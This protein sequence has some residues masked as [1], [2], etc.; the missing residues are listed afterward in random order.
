MIP[1]QT[2]VA[3]TPA[4]L[5]CLE[6]VHGAAGST[7]EGGNKHY[8]SPAKVGRDFEITQTLAP[9][10]PFQDYLTVISHTDLDPAGSFTPVE[11]GG[12]HFRSTAAFL[13]AGHARMT[14]G[15]DIFVGTSIDQIYASQFGQDTPLPSMQLCIE[16]IDGSGACDYGYS[17][18]YSDTISWATPKTPL[19]MERDPR[20]VFEM[21][22]GDGGTPAQRAARQKE[23]A[24]ILDMVARS[25]ARLQRGLPA[26]DRN[27]LNAYLEDVREIERRIQKVEK[28]NA[29][30]EA[31]AL[32]NAPV[33]VPDSFEEHANLMFD[34]Q[35]L[36]FQTGVTRVSAFKM[37]RDVCQRVFTESGVKTAFHSCSHHAENPE[38]VAE[39]ARLNQYH[40]SRVA[41]FIEKLKNTP[42]GDG[43]LLDHTLVLYGSPMGDSNVHN[44]KRLPLF[45]AGKANGKVQGNMHVM[46]PDGTPMANVLLTMMRR[47]GVNMD[48]IG[49]ST[50]EFSI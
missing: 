41:Y 8:W 11:E 43:N 2:R 14:E 47:L 26:S 39:Y 48:R 31:R 29:S 33:G 42:D 17:C 22:F 35:V 45:L 49:D 16:A 12:D 50:G 19:P 28:F 27:R 13:T 30:G 18:V 15:S 5:A 34:L 20:K 9:L 23:N 46:A 6:M 32:P 1:A 38:K 44:H 10:E 36:A 37:S 25:A 40:V 21:L 24:S 3:P 4:R 7:V